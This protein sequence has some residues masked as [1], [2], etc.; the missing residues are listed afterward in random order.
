MTKPA[1]ESPAP[2][3]QQTSVLVVG[4]GPTGLLLAAELQRRKVPCHLMEAQAAPLHWDRATVVHP[5]SLQIFE[6]MGI[7]G[8]LL[9][10]GCRQRI[11]K[12]HS[13]GDLLGTVDLGT[14]GSIY[15]YNVGVS[16]EVT[17]SILTDYLHQ[18]GGEVHRSSRLVGLEVNAHGVVADIDRAGQH[19]RM[20]SR[21]IVGCDGIHSPTRELAGIG[22]E[23]H[24]IAKPWAVFDAAVEGW[25]YPYEGNFAYLDEI[26]LILTALPGHRWRVYLRPS[27]DESDLVSDALSTLRAYLPSASFVDVANPTRFQ[28][29]TKVATKF[30]SG[31]VFLAGDAAH[32]CTPAEG[33]GM[34]T[35]LQD[36]FNLAWKLALVHHGIAGESLLDSYEPE[37]RPVAERVT[38]SGD[39]AEHAHTLADPADPAKR[40]QLIRQKLADPALL[41]Q[42]AVGEAELNIEYSQ[43]PIVFGDSN[44][45]LAAGYRLP[46]TIRVQMANRQAKLHALAHRAG[47]T[48]LLL[49]STNAQTPTVADLHR[50]LQS[51][52]SD[53]ALFEAVVAAGA[54]S[55]LPAWAGRFDANVPDL[56][57]VEGITVLAVRPDGYVGLRADRDHLAALARYDSLIRSGRTALAA[58]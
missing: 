53:S 5:R 35:G 9:L 29:H 11:I 16:E 26:P 4:A 13:S 27:S 36:A 19:Q 54:Q 34:N 48:I 25:N 14:C 39:N 10:A 40:D 22:F 45:Q 30:R 18:Q 46:D 50:A 32:L 28:C 51:V 15:G 6:A 55:D 24:D 52:A 43:S 20:E 56:L 57:G 42:E 37:R 23:G 7:V 12:V 47:H 49:A 21:W 8:K 3:P 1:D 33:H 17:E 38:R 31:P 44:S 2:P 58:G 41:H